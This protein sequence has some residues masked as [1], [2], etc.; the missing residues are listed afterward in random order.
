MMRATTLCDSNGPL[1]N[2]G[3]VKISNQLSKY[4]APTIFTMGFVI[5]GE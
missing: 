3:F 5:E 4:F 2:N 1:K